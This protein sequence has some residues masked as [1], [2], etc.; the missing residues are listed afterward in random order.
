MAYY[1]SPIIREC[2]I[3]ANSSLRGGGIHG[4]RSDPTIMNC[5]VT[6][7]SAELEGGGIYCE[8][9]SVVILNTLVTRN[10]AQKGGGISLYAVS[11]T[12]TNC[13]VTNNAG[14]ELGGA[15]HLRTSDVQAVHST[16]AG[17]FAPLAMGLA[18]E[19][20]QRESNNAEFVNCI[21]WNGNT[22][23][24]NYDSST[25]T[26]AYSDIFEGWPGEGNINADPCFAFENDYH[27]M[28]DSPCV[29]AGTI[30]SNG[31]Q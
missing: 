29:D 6:D 18:C 14:E 1:S 20:P 3:T 4:F 10:R 13:V 2:V 24:G 15:V 19:S 30:D 25:I 17:N 11:A 12:I 31:S 28:P 16:F 26:V 9:D 22:E 21:L 7:N 5:T 27:I 8:S 23:I